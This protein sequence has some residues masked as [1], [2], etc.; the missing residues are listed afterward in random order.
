MILSI[1]FETHSLKNLKK[2]G[3]KASDPEITIMAWAF[4][5]E[6][7]QIWDPQQGSMP[8][9]VVDHVRNGGI[10]RGWNVTYE[11][12]VWNRLASRSNWIPRLEAEQLDDTMA[13]AAY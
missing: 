7:V 13:R 12:E 8:E 6:P 5:N 11:F 1:D 10:V 4:D 3:A 2:T 9:R